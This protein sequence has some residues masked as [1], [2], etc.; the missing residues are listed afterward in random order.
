MGHLK[1]R[2]WILNKNIFRIWE[3][4]FGVIRMR[5][6]KNAHAT[7]ASLRIFE[8]IRVHRSILHL[9]LV[10]RGGIYTPSGR[11]FVVYT[12]TTPYG[13]KRLHVSKQTI[14]L[15]RGGQL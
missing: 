9:G 2:T 11:S 12:P 10:F 1:V 6:T 14:D 8:I 5:S 3:G 4:G 15:V 13:K 7:P